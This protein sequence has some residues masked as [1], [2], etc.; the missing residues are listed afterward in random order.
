MLNSAMNATNLVKDLQSLLGADLVSSD[1][2]SRQA[3]SRDA[4]PLFDGLP[5]VIVAPRTTEDV[6]KLVKYA[7]VN[8]VPIIPRGAGSNL[9]GAT[10]PVNGGIVLNMNNMNTIAQIYIFVDVPRLVI[11]YY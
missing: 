5:E 8:K 7:A 4:T 9:C 3:Y 2:V 11:I 1:E 6:V 10:V